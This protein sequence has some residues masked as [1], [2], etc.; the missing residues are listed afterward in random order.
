MVVVVVVFVVV[1]VV[2]VVVVFVVMVV[3]VAFVVVVVMVVVNT[4]CVRLV[5]CPTSS[6]F[7]HDSNTSTCLQLATQ[8]ANWSDASSSCHA[9]HQRAHLVVINNQTKQKAVKMFIKGRHI[10]SG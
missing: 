3:V 6:G 10:T 7:T 2:V 5:Y 4:V 9:L 1:V 8:S